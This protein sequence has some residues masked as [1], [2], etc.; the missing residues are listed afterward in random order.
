MNLNRLDDPNYPAYSIGQAAELL[1]CQQAFLRS[2]DSAGM[3]IPGRSEGGHRRYSRHQ[4]EQASRART[5]LDEGFDLTAAARVLTL[6]DELRKAKA[7]LARERQA[8]T[9][10]QQRRRNG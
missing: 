6:E 8:R 1:G 10:E 9:R 3:V 5:L 4:L 7:A 2:L